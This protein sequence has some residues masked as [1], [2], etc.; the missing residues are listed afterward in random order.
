VGVQ[1]IAV[2]RE[3]LE[4]RDLIR[5]LQRAR[6]SSNRLAQPALASDLKNELGELYVM[7]VAYPNLESARV[8]AERETSAALLRLL[9]DAGEG[10][11]AHRAAVLVAADDLAVRL[12]SLLV[13]R[14]IG[15]G[16]EIL[17]EAP[18]AETLREQLAP[19]GVK[20]TGIGHYS[21]DLEYDRSLLSRAWAEFPETPWGQRAFLMLQRLSCS[22]PQ[23]GCEGLD[24]FRAVIKQ[25]EQFLS[26]FPETP[27]RHEQT[28]FLAIAY[29]TWWGLSQ[30]AED[31]PTAEGAL[32]ESEESADRARRQ[33]ISLYEELWRIAPESPEARLGQLRLPRLKL[34]LGSGERTFFCFTC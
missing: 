23:F 31:D 11:P 2:R 30:A 21:G 25:G 3:I 17:A 5:D 12:G 14:S 20:Y 34:G 24:C 9:R 8:E 10:E 13:R 29:E 15:S 1:L 4:E 27:F 33:A 22:L 28:Y 26:D 18:A 32:V 7:P 19:Y 6:S 16:A